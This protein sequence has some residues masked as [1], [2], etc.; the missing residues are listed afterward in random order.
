MS[1]FESLA[2]VNEYV[3]SHDKRDFVDVIKVKGFEMERLIWTQQDNP[4]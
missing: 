4:G 3:I 1:A 2:P